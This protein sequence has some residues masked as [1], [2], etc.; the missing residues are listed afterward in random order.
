MK[1]IC[2]AKEFTEALGKAAKAVSPKSTIPALSG[3]LLNLEKN[4]LHITGYNMEIGIDT[5]LTVQ[6]VEDGAIVTNAAKLFVG[7]MNRM[8][9]DVTVHTE[10]SNIIIEN[11]RSKMDFLG[12]PAEDFPRLPEFDDDNVK[13]I[14]SDTL[15]AAIGHVLYAADT[16][17]INA[18]AGGVL[19][20][21][22]NGAFTAVTTNGTVIAK[23]TERAAAEDFRV[24]VPVEAMKILDATL[25]VDDVR[26]NP[27]RTLIAFSCGA[28]TV[29]ARTLEDNFLNYKT[30]FSKLGQKDEAIF[31]KADLKEVLERVKLLSDGSAK[32]HNPVQLFFG[33]SKCDINLQSGGSKMAESLDVKY[34]GKAL[35]IKVSA[36]KLL[37]AINVIDGDKV[38]LGI[39]GELMPIV[40]GSEMDECYI[41]LVMPIRQK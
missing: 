10:E 34:S 22:E 14:P 6:G 3:L 21:M 5:A 27:T 18:S 4:R 28:T 8:K 25:S 20:N 40:I 41:A 35:N 33:G 9:N 37:N 36:T 26:I 32:L 2:N 11:G 1:F 16:Q 31:A 24:L 29:I 13:I 7:M 15:K 17:N 30:I 38:S 23:H 39:S 12:L 19:L